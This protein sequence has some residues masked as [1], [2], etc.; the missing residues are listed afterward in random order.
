M[1][2]GMSATVSPAAD[3]RGGTDMGHTGDIAETGATPRRPFSRRA[4]LGAA[5]AGASG[6][7]LG[8]RALLTPASYARGLTDR[9]ER[10]AFLDSAA[11]RQPGSL[12]NP[13]VAPGTPSMPEIENIVVVMM[14]NHSFDNVLVM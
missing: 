14:E 5:A 3:D 9:R 8:G 11:I 7:A 10:K 13:A 2:Q 1:V 12:P 6:L 4:L